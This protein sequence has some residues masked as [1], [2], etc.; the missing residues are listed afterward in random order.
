[1]KSACVQLGSFLDISNSSRRTD[2][3]E[4]LFLVI[5]CT[6]SF[7]NQ[8]ENEALKRDLDEKSLRLTDL[9]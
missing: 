8:L 7:G 5:S 6:F 4:M 3:L 1:M 2:S 9:K